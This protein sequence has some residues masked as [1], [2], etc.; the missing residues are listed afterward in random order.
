MAVVFLARIEKMVDLESPFTLY[1]YRMFDSL[2]WIIPPFLPI[3][4]S[5]SLTFSLMRL[6]FHNIMGVEPQ[7]TLLAGKVTHMCF[8]KVSYILFKSYSSLSAVFRQELL[9]QMG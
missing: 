5:L 6:R 8:D 9:Q 4:E 3:F 7:K 1:L 2:T